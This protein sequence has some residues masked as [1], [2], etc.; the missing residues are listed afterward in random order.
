MDIRKIFGANIRRIRLAAR[1]SQEAIAERMGV[2]R[3][4]VSGME[5]GRQNATLLT[6]WQVSQALS[7][8]PMEL[9]DEGAPQLT[10]NAR[11]KR[12]PKRT[13]LGKR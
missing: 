2:D 3:A 10:A 7:V 8:R 1:L 12:A 11:S 13:H 6:I 9:L 5:R 4:F